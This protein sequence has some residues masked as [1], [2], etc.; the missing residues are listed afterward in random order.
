MSHHLSPAEVYHHKLTLLQ[1]SG[2]AVHGQ[3]LS[4]A[5]LQDKSRS[6]LGDTPRD[7][8][9]VRD[10]VRAGWQEYLHLQKLPPRDLDV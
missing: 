9:R 6:S 1:V 5:H 3:E 10:F 4:R 2:V 8:R 7:T